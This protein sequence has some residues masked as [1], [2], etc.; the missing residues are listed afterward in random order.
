MN[1]SCNKSHY[2]PW[3]KGKQVGQKTPSKLEEIWA[4]RVRLQI[5]HR[6][7]QLVLFNLWLDSKLRACDLVK[8]QGSRHLSW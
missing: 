7:T 8:T 4:I 5:E 6:V 2:E 3:N 1:E